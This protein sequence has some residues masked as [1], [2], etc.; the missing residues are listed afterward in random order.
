MTYDLPDWYHLLL[1]DKDD[2]HA[3]IGLDKGELIIRSSY[4][5]YFDNKR[6]I[7]LKDPCSQADVEP[8]FFLHVYPVDSNDLPAQSRQRGYDT[9]DFSFA[10]QG[11]RSGGKC[12]AIRELPRYALSRLETGQ[13]TSGEGG[14]RVIWEG[15]LPLASRS[16]GGR[17]APPV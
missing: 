15:S 5:V 4:D 10:G 11:F 16:R 7:Y 13:F 17:W 9:L 2:T 14:A 1:R 3:N 8:R 6:V 12:L